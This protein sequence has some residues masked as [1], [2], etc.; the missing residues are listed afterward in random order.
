MREGEGGPSAGAVDPAPEGRL[1]PVA[2]SYPSPPSA[3]A[4]ASPY[5][6]TDN[7][8]VTLS[9]SYCTCGLSV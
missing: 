7:T 8:S 6:R 5:T 3:S 2:L 4:T 9:S 1:L